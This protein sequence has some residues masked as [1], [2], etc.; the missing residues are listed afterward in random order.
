M[1][2]ALNRYLKNTLSAAAL[3]LSLAA[4]QSP[5]WPPAVPVL[6]VTAKAGST[7]L[8]DY[9]SEMRKAIILQN[10]T[11]SLSSAGP[12]QLAIH[13]HAPGRTALIVTYKNGESRMYDVV[14]VPS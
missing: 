9:G 8:L 2:K 13:A 10:R 11:A 12:H 5:L 14:V 6:S 7:V 1:K 4:L 3:V